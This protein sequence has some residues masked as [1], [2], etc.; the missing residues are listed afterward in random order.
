MQRADGKRRLEETACK[1]ERTQTCCLRLLSEH[2]EADLDRNETHSS[3]CALVDRTPRTLFALWLTRSL[4]VG[5]PLSRSC[6]AALRVVPLSARR[7]MQ[8]LAACQRPGGAFL[9]EGLSKVISCV[10]TPVVAAAAGADNGKKA[11]A[12]PAA[13]ASSSS[14]SSSSSAAPAVAAAPAGPTFDVVLSETV[15]FP[16]G[17]GQPTDTGVLEFQGAGGSA[18]QARVLFVARTPNGIVHR[19]ERAVPVGAEVTVRVDWA[20]RFDHMQCHSTQH[21][22]SAVARSSLGFKTLSWWLASAPQECFIELDTGAAGMSPA[23]MSQV[24]AEVNTWIRGGSPMKLHTWPSLSEARCDPFF[25]SNISKSIPDSQEG[26]IRVM[27]IPNLEF[28]PCC[29]T[30][31]ESLAQMGAVKLTKVEK[32]KTSS[33]LFFLTGD[34]TLAAL[35]A[36]LDVQRALT[37]S[38]CCSPDGFADAVKR[39]QAD[40][41]STSKQLANVMKELAENDA[42]KLVAGIRSAAAAP[43]ASPSAQLLSRDE[44]GLNYLADVADKVSDAF[45]AS[46]APAPYLLLLCSSDTASGSSGAFILFGDEGLVAAL[47]P[48]LATKLTGKGGGRKGK[49]Q[50]KATGMDAKSRAAALEWMQQS[51]AQRAAKVE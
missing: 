45:K 19:V 6:A 9:K 40:F 39:L 36:A 20:R 42:T 48:E 10:E 25:T 14:A 27:E 34:R 44:F 50:G 49:F 31:L 15:L 7:P 23:Q 35:G 21:L 16:E 2:S 13:A 24:E 46:P 29:G 26:A 11:K 12:A 30:H 32:G 18:E 47:G 28:N 33:K 38:L 41:K 37:A 1:R 43:G 5:Q 17:G 22:I 4:R 8:T 3:L 51:L